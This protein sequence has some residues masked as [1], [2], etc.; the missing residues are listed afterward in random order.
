MTTSAMIEGA[1]AKMFDMFNE[2]ARRNEERHQLLMAAMGKGA[3]EPSPLNPDQS[4]ESYSPAPPTLKELHV[5]VAVPVHHTV[6]IQKP[7]FT[8]KLDKKTKA[9]VIGKR[10]NKAVTTA[11]K[12]SHKSPISA[13][14][15]LN[16]YSLKMCKIKKRLHD[17]PVKL[18]HRCSDHCLL[19]SIRKHLYQLEPNCLAKSRHRLKLLYRLRSKFRDDRYNAMEHG[20][21]EILNIGS[22]D[23]ANL[24]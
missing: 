7:P 12:I 10:I 18:F 5:S 17:K 24:I 22:Q 11:V 1:L 15:F 8:V 19:H 6:A 14:N 4:K 21:L 23:R 3:K 13:K 2:F 16:E 20:I 9:K